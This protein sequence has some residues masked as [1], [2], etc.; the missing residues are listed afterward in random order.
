MNDT[1][2]TTSSN[3]PVKLTHKTLM[4]SLEQVR[5]QK[6]AL[7]EWMKE[8]G[9]D[10]DKGGRLIMNREMA[11][12]IYDGYPLPSCVVI[13]KLAMKYFSHPVLMMTY[14][15]LLDVKHFNP[16]ILKEESRDGKEGK[17]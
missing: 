17:K 13:N 1:T 6:C 12:E 7:T 10:P 8:K 4:A 9:F 15:H 5:D 14:E 2:S 3:K 16:I 11:F